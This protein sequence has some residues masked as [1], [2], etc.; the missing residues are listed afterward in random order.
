MKNC[1]FITD[2][3]WIPALRLRGDRLGGNDGR[4]HPSVLPAK[5]GIQ[6]AY[7]GL[8]GLIEKLRRNDVTRLFISNS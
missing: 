3:V 7:G 2:T 1:L 5:A 4:L 6:S 8:P